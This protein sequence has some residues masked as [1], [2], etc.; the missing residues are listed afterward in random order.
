MSKNKTV[1]TN[2]SVTK[3]LDS[4]DDPIKKEGSKQIHKMMQELSGLKAVMWGESII[5]YGTYHYKYDSGREGDFL[6]IGFSPRKQNFAFYIMN[7]AARYEDLLAKLGKHKTGKS[8]L[9][10]N[11]LADV[12]LEILEEICRRSYD[13]MTEKYG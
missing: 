9:Y 8:C 4:I 11:R 7:G 6:K 3:Y 13:A 12:D 5:G 1:A 2:L 10:I